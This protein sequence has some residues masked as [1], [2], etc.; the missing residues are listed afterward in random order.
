MTQRLP[1]GG[2]FV[3]SQDLLTSIYVGKSK[4]QPHTDKLPVEIVGGPGNAACIE[5]IGICR[6]ANSLRYIV[7]GHIDTCN[8]IWINSDKLYV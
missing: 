1:R 4:E 7:Q 2:L 6:H 8:F 5:L 3:L